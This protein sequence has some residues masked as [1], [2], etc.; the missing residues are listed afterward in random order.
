MGLRRE[1]GKIRLRI[2]DN[3]KGIDT[4]EK[5]GPRGIGMTGMRARAR[6]AGGELEILTAGK[7]KGLTIEAWVPSTPLT[8]EQEDT[9]LISR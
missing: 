5:S 6:S 2:S 4:A 8:D 9:N 7:E 1:D 3:G